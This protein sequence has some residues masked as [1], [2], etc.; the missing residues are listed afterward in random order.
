MDPRTLVVGLLAPWFLKLIWRQ[1]SLVVKS[2][3]LKPEGM[4]SLL[5]CHISCGISASL[6]LDCII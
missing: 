3:G 4:V 5:L 6:N 1:F 2:K